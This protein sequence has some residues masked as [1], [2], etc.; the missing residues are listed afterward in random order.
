[1]FNN[2]KFMRDFIE[3]VVGTNQPFTVVDSPLFRKWVADLRPVLA[4]KL[5]HSTQLREQI[6]KHFADARQRFKDLIKVCQCFTLN[7]RR[8]LTMK[9]QTVGSG[10]DCS[11]K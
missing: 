10:S 1:M 3:W 9:Q 8:V 2:E 11:C 6:D 5:V 7:R 4:T